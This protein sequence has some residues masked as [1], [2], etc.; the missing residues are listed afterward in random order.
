MALD[1]KQKKLV[2]EIVE[3]GKTQ[4]YL[5][6]DDVLERFPEI[7]EDMNFLEYLINILQ[8]HEIE[9]IEPVEEIEE[10]E[11]VVVPTGKGMTFEQ[12]ISILRKIRSHVSTDPIR[13]Y[14]HE[15]GRIPLL[16]AEEEVILAKNIE[17]GDQESREL[18]TTANL[19][20]VVKSSLDS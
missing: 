20:L 11:I 10:E 7:E 12:K 14:L 18:L 1:Q 4:G 19:R 5:T 2:N 16:T 9:I 8:E 17:A 15:I 3:L 13:A 6:Q